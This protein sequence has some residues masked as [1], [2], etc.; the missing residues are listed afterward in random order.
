VI[1]TDAEMFIA[2]FSQAQAL[3][4]GFSVNAFGEVDGKFYRQSAVV[5]E[6]NRLKPCPIM[7]F[8]RSGPLMLAEK[9]ASYRVHISR[10]IVSGES[11]TSCGVL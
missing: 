5:K 3:P 6:I 7:T 1:E 8:Q 9:R 4:V 10:A 11:V 2:E